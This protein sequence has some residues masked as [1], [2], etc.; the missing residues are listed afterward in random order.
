VLLL[1]ESPVGAKRWP[2]S[3]PNTTEAPTPA[4]T[5]A[6][7]LAERQPLSLGVAPLHDG[8]VLDGLAFI[9]EAELY[10]GS[11]SRRAA[12]RRAAQ[13]LA[14]QLAARPHRTEG[15]RPGGA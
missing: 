6:A 11:P 2:N 3:S 14:R 10:A 12:P 1:A 15:R 13:G 5:F 4:P 9:T 8:F 7:F